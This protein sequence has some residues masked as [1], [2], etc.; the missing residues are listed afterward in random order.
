[1]I[2]IAEIGM[3]LDAEETG[4]CEWLLPD[5]RL[6]RHV[7]AMDATLAVAAEQK[8]SVGIPANC[9]RGELTQHKIDLCRGELVVGTASSAAP[10][11]A[12]CFDDA[13]AARIRLEHG[14][15]TSPRCAAAAT[16]STNREVG[17]H[18]RA[19][20][21]LVLR[22]NADA[23]LPVRAESVYA[24][25][26]QISDRSKTHRRVERCP[27][28]GSSGVAGVPWQLVTLMRSALMI[29]RQLPRGAPRAP[30]LF[31][32]TR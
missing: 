25:K 31:T 10:S 26:L 3:A 11:Q 28:P 17:S 19:D 20:R 7:H 22:Q 13:G 15:G 16:A 1:M 4:F 27:F 8:L 32:I 18:H 6:A 24:R 29:S 23:T 2:A 9:I 12:A 30:H 5:Y 21:E 14:L